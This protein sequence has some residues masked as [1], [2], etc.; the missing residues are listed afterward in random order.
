MRRHIVTDS[1]FLPYTLLFPNP[2][3]WRYSNVQTPRTQISQRNVCNRMYI[4]FSILYKTSPECATKIPK[5]HPKN[6]DFWRKNTLFC[7]TKQAENAQ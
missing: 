6:K 1:A 5:N 2:L 4:H 3:E 7:L